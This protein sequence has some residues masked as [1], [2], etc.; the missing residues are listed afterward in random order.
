MEA[1][2]GTLRL[3][4]IG[5]LK[6]KLSSIVALKLTEGEMVT[7]LNAYFV[8]YENEVHMMRTVVATAKKIKDALCTLA[9]I[10]VRI[11][12]NLGARLSLRLRG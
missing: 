11:A 6:G 10:R 2:L 4:L 8:A 3:M 7:S 5:E 1:A 12:A 9:A